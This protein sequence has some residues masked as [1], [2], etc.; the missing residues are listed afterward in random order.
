MTSPKHTTHA[1]T[2]CSMSSSEGALPAGLTPQR[3]RHHHRA[4][5]PRSGAPSPPPSPSVLDAYI[6]VSGDVTVTVAPN[7][8]CEVGDTIEQE[9]TLY[10]VGDEYGSGWSAGEITAVNATITGSDIFKIEGG[11]LVGTPTAPGFYNVTLTQE[12]HLRRGLVRHAHG[13]RDDDARRRSHRRGDRSARRQGHHLRRGDRKRLP[14]Q[15]LRR[16]L[17]RHLQR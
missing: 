9:V 15:L 7:A 3:E 8:T 13:H 17:H 4:P 10:Q 12:D 11:K 14:H 16:H 6:Q 5:R 1:E 2:P